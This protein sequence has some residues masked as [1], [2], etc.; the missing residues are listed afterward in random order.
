M[1]DIKNHLPERLKKGNQQFNQA[2]I[3]AINHNGDKLLEQIQACIDQFF[4][5]T[6]NGKYLV[7]LGEQEGFTMPPNS[8]LDIRAYRVLV[9]LMVS[10]PKQVRRTFEE[11]IEAFYGSSVT[12]PSIVATVAEP[13]NLADGDDMQI[14]TEKGTILVSILASAVSNIAKVSAS[15]LAVMI[16][17]IQTNVYADTIADRL[18]NQRYLRLS[19]TTNGAS[20]F[21][22]VV[23]GTAQN[24]IKFPH[25]VNC[26]QQTGTTW[27]ITKEQPYSD[28]M[29]IKWNGLG[30]PPKMYLVQ[31]GDAV[32]IRG[33]LSPNELINGSYEILD[34]GYDYFVVRNDTLFATNASF[35]Q[36][37]DDQVIF[38]SQ[39]NITIY[40]NSEYGL[41]GETEYNTATIT[42]PAIPPLARRFL[43]G[44]SHLHGSQS[45]VTAFT[46]SSIQLE[47]APGSDRPNG[48]NQFVIRNQ[49][50]MYNFRQPYYKTEGVD[51]SLTSPLYSM[52]ST[53]DKYSVLP[54]TTPMLIGATSIH[55]EV[56]SNELTVSFP[57]AH[58]L[59][60]GW[61]TTL[62]NV[63]PI[64]N[65]TSVLLNKEYVVKRFLSPI[66]I[67]LEVLNNDPLLLGDKVLFSG[68]EFGT[69]DILRYGTLQ[70]DGSDFYLEFPSEAALIA[71]GL[72]LNQTFRIKAESG[73]DIAFFYADNIKH[74]LLQVQSIDGNRVNILTGLG[75]G[76]PTVITTGAL[77]ERSADFGGATATYVCDTSSDWNKANVLANMQACMLAY[78]PSVNTGYVGSYVYDPQGYA[79]ILTVSKY[80][81][82]VSGDILKGSSEGVIYIDKASNIIGTEGFPQSGKLVIDYGSTGSEGPINYLAVIDGG[83][84]ARSQIILDPAY[85]FTKTHKIGAQVQYVHNVYPY[86]PTING[87]DYPV[88]ITGTA[89]ARNTLFKLMESL[90]ASGIFLQPDVLLPQLRYQDTAIEPFA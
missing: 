36:S 64:G 58:G 43:S 84:T 75:A 13:Y 12:K 32:T 72:Q 31:K 22:R 38:T 77:G 76:T 1:A 71:S 53:E 23:G 66:S 51:Q 55:C 2:L 8:G 6:A 4:L 59:L 9:P 87:S 50:M 5:S 68:V 80:I 73:T 45:N 65:F 67:V 49:R 16:N 44:S 24:V 28:V 81:T 57:Y 48:V 90:V 88:Y 35:S 19:S 41:A 14:V 85:R 47:L 3:K 54:Y 15:E 29:K 17:T 42:I 83:G 78:T 62:N 46:R 74:R 39:I 61:G 33:L 26:D 30:V 52:V 25:V 63:D 89:Q 86:Q 34:S 37:T 10:S 82:H 18:T 69:F 60:V 56:G 40:D 27:N 79:T 21:I 70:D 7:Q 20:G 11:I